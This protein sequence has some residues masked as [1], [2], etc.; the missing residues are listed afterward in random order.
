MYSE[1]KHST[2]NF[3]TIPRG[4]FGKLC[5]KPPVALTPR[6]HMGPIVE[7]AVPRRSDELP[8]PSPSKDVPND[9]SLRS[10]S[11]F[12][13]V[14]R[15]FALMAPNSLCA[16][17]KAARNAATSFSDKTVTLRLAVPASQRCLRYVL[18]PLSRSP[19]ATVPAI[20]HLLYPSPCWPRSQ[21]Q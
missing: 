1:G 17:A 21:L 4:K 2:G 9:L 11:N 3:G 19:M 14:S 16:L 13:S 15:F 10:L 6:V 12:A 18:P 5:L 8:P 7:A 20:S